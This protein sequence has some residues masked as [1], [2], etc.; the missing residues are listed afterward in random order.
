MDDD[1]NTPVALQILWKLVR[2]EKAI[3]KIQTIK[4]FDEV[5]G[6]DLL[7][8]EMVTVPANI[9]KLVADREKARKDKD[10]KTADEIRNKINKLGY[11]LDDTNNGVKVSK[12]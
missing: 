11:Q 3:G 9:Q 1:L 2:D 10:F 8:V 7:K 12:K 5:F 6:L 4:K